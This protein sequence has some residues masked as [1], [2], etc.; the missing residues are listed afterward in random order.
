MEPDLFDAVV[1][2]GGRPDLAGDMLPKVKAST[3]LLVGG[4][5][6]DVHQLNIEAMS[7]LGSPGSIRLAGFLTCVLATT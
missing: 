4:W 1:S 2:R 7:R 5:D 3:L 6:A